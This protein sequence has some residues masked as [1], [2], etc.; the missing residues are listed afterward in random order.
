MNT[1]NNRL[2]AMDVLRG[3][4][5]L[6]ILIVNIQSFSMP[7]AAYLNPTAFGDL[8]GINFGVWIS[9]H[10]LADQ[11]FM[12]LFSMLFGA[13]VVLFCD[14]ATQKGKS[15]AKLHYKRNFWLLIL[16]LAHAYLFWYGDILVAYSLCAFFVYL[17]RNKSI[18]TL[19]TI[20]LVLLLISSL[21]SFLVGSSLGH[22]PAE[23]KS[24]LMEAWQPDSAALQKELQAYTGSFTSA[25][26][27][28]AEEAAFMQSYVFLTYF[29]WRASAMMLLGMAL[30]K[31]GFFQQA[32][33]SRSY[34][35][36]A[37][38]GLII[39]LPTVS[40][41]VYSNLTHGF[42]LEYSMFLGSQFNYWGSIFVALAYASIVLLIVKKGLF[43]G[44][45]ARLAAIGKTA[46]SN[47]ILHTLVFTTLFY[48]YGFSL[49]G[50]VERWQQLLMVVSMWLLQLWLAPVWLRYYQFGPLEW[51]WRTLTYG[52][53]QPFKKA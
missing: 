35:I 28:R 15:A 24:G 7:G 23:A 27:V 44:I 43:S 1:D 16:G 5:L 45:Q 22:F 30:Y 39:G 12:S 6:G 41:G 46:F 19:L 4:A 38:A 8:N 9:T 17:L 47:Y 29:F 48:G 51:L 14:K 36:L 21:Y 49:F 11:K 31:S 18:P 50:D 40:Y 10:V 3:F 33:Q 32:W 53:L 13:G 2:L 42:S 25:L 52:K 37:L 34:L 26:S 20:A